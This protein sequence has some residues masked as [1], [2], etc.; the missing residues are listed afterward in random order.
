MR[1]LPAALLIPAG[2]LGAILLL[3]PGRT[4]ITMA[5]LI[6]CNVFSVLGVSGG[7]ATTGE[8]KHNDLPRQWRDGMLRVVF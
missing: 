7:K 1:P 3:P 5:L 6:L 2:L 4:Y 8:L